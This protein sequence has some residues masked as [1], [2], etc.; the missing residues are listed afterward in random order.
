[1]GKPILEHVLDKVKELGPRRIHLVTNDKFASNFE[2]LAKLYK[3]PD[4]HVIN[5]KTKSNDDRLGQIGDIQLVID[6]QK[7]D[8]DLVILAGDNLFN[9]SL[10]DAHTVF[11]E[12]GK[13]VNAAFDIG[14]TA[15]ARHL[16]VLEVDHRNRI[17]AFQEKP[18]HPKSTLVSLGIYF[19]PRKHVP[20]ISE[21][22]A[23]GNSPDKMGHFMEWL[24]ERE[25]VFTHIY[26]DQW[27]DI[28]VP[29]QLEEARRDFT[30]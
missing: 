20:L 22:L 24:L 15:H 12:H 16:G 26:K 23:Q 8:D 28:G 25:Q 7:I 27:F 4:L 29:E 21:Y 5:D 11:V 10:I 18:E 6:T 30:P 1:A 13:P 19:F 3:H 14:N 17:T 9:F 2:D